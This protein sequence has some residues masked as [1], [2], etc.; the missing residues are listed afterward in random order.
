MV[1]SSLIV[2]WW[3]VAHRDVEVHTRGCRWHF[4]CSLLGVLVG[5]WVICT[6][7]TCVSFWFAVAEF[8]A[9]ESSDRYKYSGSPSVIDECITALIYFIMYLVIGIG[10]GVLTLLPLHFIFVYCILYI[11]KY[12]C[13]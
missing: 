4:C 13:D 11:L 1:V 5:L 7:L 9:V 6:I 10:L 12:I 8:V 2:L 3:V